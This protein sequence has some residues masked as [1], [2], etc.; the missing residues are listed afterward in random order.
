MTNEEENAIIEAYLILDEAY[1][2]LWCKELPLNYEELEGLSVLF[3]ARDYIEEQIPPYLR[4]T[5]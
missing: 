4:G 5:Y 1:G 2:E 3:H